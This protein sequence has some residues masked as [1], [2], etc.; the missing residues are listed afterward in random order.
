MRV[1][2]SGRGMA[3]LVVVL[4]ASGDAALAA[5]GYRYE[6]PSDTTYTT[7]STPTP[8]ISG[9]GAGAGTSAPFAVQV[10]DTRRA[11][12]FVHTNGFVQLG[13]SFGGSQSCLPAMNFAPP[14]VF[15]FWASSADLAA[16]GVGEGVFTQTLGDAPNRRFIVEWRGHKPG[17]PD[18]DRRF[19]VVFYESSPVITT[20]YSSPGVSGSDA[21]IGVSKGPSGPHTQF[22][23]DGASI[24]GAHADRLH[25][26]PAESLAAH[27]ER[28][29]ARRRGPPGDDRQLGRH[30]ADLL[31]LPVA[32]LRLRRHGR[33]RRHR[34]RDGRELRTR[35]AGR[36]PPPAPAR[37]GDEHATPCT[38]T[39]T[40]PTPP[41]RPSCKPARRDR[42]EAPAGPVAPAAGPSGRRRSP[43]WP[44][45]RRG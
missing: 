27:G 5:P 4:L 19:E 14:T 21:T 6:L 32:A 41:R 28:H 22:S 36:E 30:R 2:V 23:C 31:R 17:M 40:P 29:R 12:L 38:S 13:G 37:E 1:R 26:G 15:P 39:T 44:C 43:R 16:N 7:V 24:G 34:R 20:V 33:L 10:Y 3:V 18:R 45:R 11:Q 25:P 42:V 9:T 8:V 35:S